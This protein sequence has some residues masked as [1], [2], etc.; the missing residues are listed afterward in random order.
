MAAKN[1]GNRRKGKHS[2]FSF[3][4]DMTPEKKTL[5]CK[6][7]GLAIFI[8][9]AITFVSAVSYLFTWKA[10]QSL[11]SHPEMMDKGV[12]VANMCGKFGLSHES[13]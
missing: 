3:F 8:F 7:T 4:S 13:Q 2:R 11:L 10:D 12:E 5:Y 1:T 6:Y 9:T